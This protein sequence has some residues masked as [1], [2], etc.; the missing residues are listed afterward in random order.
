MKKYLTPASKIK[1]KMPIETG[2]TEPNKLVVCLLF[3]L[4]LALDE[5][6]D[7]RDG[8]FMNDEYELTSSVI[9]AGFNDF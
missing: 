8:F 7:I 1:L 4:A 3:C 9:R 2:P 6:E 5:P